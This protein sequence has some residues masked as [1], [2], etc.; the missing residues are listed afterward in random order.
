MAKIPLVFY[1]TAWGLLF[2]VFFMT[3]VFVDSDGGI[4]DG[5]V[6]IGIWMMNTPD[7]TGQNVKHSKNI[8]DNELFTMDSDCTQIKC[9]WGQY[10]HVFAFLSLFVL[11]VDLA[12]G[13]KGCCHWALTALTHLLV[14]GLLLHVILT[15]SL[16]GK[17]VDSNGFECYFGYGYSPAFKAGDG[18]KLIYSAYALAICGLLVDI[19]S[20][21][22]GKCEVFR[23]EDDEMVEA[24]L[25]RP[26]SKVTKS[27]RPSRR[28]TT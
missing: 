2:P 28:Y 17:E 9:R 24:L 7:A 26:S 10:L 11:A 12:H 25:E 14:F 20:Y 18:A 23:P 1:V 16:I 27:A 4:G 6:D 5:G 8:C 19:V 21:K 13:N 22:I 15:L 3:S